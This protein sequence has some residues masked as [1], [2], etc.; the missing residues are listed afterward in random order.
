MS[1]RAC[2]CVYMYVCMYVCALKSL[3]QQGAV[4]SCYVYAFSFLKFKMD[5]SADCMFSSINFSKVN[6][7]NFIK[8]ST[9]IFIFINH[10]WICLCVCLFHSEANCLFFFF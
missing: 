10:S 8:T 1:V 9:M 4:I 7:Y 2:V 5:V 3:L 6:T